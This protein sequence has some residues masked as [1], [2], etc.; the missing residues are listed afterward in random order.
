M[1]SKYDSS[2]LYGAGKD[3]A[4]PNA[5]L[6]L[7]DWTGRSQL[8]ACCCSVRFTS[9]WREAGRVVSRAREE[10]RAIARMRRRLESDRCD[11][12][13]DTLDSA[14]NNTSSPTACSYCCAVSSDWKRSA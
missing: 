9:G 11:A 2:V 6:L 14:G 10:D 7:E 13:V 4:A 3:G 8:A 5:A 12:T 1:E